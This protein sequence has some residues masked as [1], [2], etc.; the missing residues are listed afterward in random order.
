MQGHQQAVGHKSGGG[1]ALPVAMLESNDI[2]DAEAWL[3]LDA[4]RYVP[5][6]TLPVDA[7]FTN[8]R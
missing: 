1:N 8:K 2:S 6:V 3:V 5:G 4:A 7:G